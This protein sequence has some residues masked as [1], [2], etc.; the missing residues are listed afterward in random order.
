MQNS[1]QQR[2]LRFF[3]ICSLFLSLS[4]VRF[5]SFGLDYQDGEEVLCSGMFVQR[6][7]RLFWISIQS[8][9]SRPV[10]SSSWDQGIDQDQ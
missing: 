4:T 3:W 1:K 5:L 6:D 2:E 10:V 7:S 9:A 8:G